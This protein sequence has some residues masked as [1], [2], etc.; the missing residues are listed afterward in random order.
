MVSGV[1]VW[2]IFVLEIGVVA[3][4]IDWD[5]GSWSTGQL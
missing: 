4:G 3:M 5:I 2:W 1:S